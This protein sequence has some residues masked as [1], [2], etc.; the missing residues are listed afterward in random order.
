MYYFHI[1]Y[2]F[3]RRFHVVLQLT[4]RLED[5]SQRQPIACYAPLLCDT[6]SHINCTEARADFH[7][8]VHGCV[9]LSTFMTISPNYFQPIPYRK[10]LD[11]S[12]SQGPALTAKSVVRLRAT[13]QLTVKQCWYFDW[14]FAPSKLRFKFQFAA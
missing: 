13:L 12:P 7:Y 2:F 8:L 1:P 4:E 9:S 14:Q 11:P 3:A 5:A 10:Q 6:P